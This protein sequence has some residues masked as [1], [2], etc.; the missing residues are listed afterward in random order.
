MA[1]NLSYFTMMS[2]P[3]ASN[4]E[5]S[6]MVGTVLDDKTLFSVLGNDF[7]GFLASHR[8]IMNEVYN[9]FS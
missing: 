9:F 7:R 4:A 2:F 5:H 1:M 6:S 3:K 8:C